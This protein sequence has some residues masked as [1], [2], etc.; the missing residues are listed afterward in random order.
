[1]LVGGRF[2]VAQSDFREAYARVGPRRKESSRARRSDHQLCNRSIAIGVA[3]PLGQV[4]G[5]PTQY[6]NRRRSA[7]MKRWLFT[8]SLSR[9]ERPMTALRQRMIED[10]KLRNLAPRTTQVYVERVATF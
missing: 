1:M 7:T 5:G 2:H 6:E 3:V 9:K 8:P 10:M 4:T